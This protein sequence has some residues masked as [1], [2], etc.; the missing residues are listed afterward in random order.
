MEQTESPIHEA[1]EAE[2]AVEADTTE[3]KP[4]VKHGWLR[5]LILFVVYVVGIIGV[6]IM[7]GLVF[8]LW[9]VVTGRDPFDLE[10]LADP[11]SL[12]LGPLW[13]SQLLHFALTVI[14]VWGMRRFIDR[15]SFVSLGLTLRGYGSHLV[16]GMAW[17]VGL[18]VFGF[19]VL[20]ATGALVIDPE[21]ETIGP[22]MFLAYLG[23][24]I[25]VAVNEEL[26]IRGYVL[27]N[28][29]ASMN[30]WVALFVSALIFTAFHIFNANISLLPLV[31]L[32]LAG[33]VLGVYYIHRRNL[34]FSIGMHLTWNLFQGPVFG[35]EVSGL[36][37][38]SVIGQTVSG[39]DLLTGGDFGLEGSILTTVFLVVAT[40]VIHLQFRNDRPVLRSRLKNRSEVH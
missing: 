10:H 39:S 28:L 18:I 15:R 7:T 27:D 26:V 21:H 31:N 6:S 37:T 11:S 36:Q 12:G 20:Q 40:I 35:F 33:M 38:P 14:V 32:V 19:V 2:A 8:V 1:V 17:G 23:I 9:N 30:R 3:P 34:W 25:V 29:M 24:L 4:L 22:L 5:V 13:V 16:Q